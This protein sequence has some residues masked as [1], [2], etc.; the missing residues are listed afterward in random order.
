MLI[1]RDDQEFLLF[2]EQ[3]NENTNYYIHVDNPKL[4]HF[5]SRCN[6]LWELVPPSTITMALEML[7]KFYNEELVYLSKISKDPEHIKKKLIEKYDKKRAEVVLHT[8]KTS[9]NFDTEL[10]YQNLKSDLIEIYFTS[11]KHGYKIK[12]VDDNPYHWIVSFFDFEPTSHIHKDVEHLKEISALDSI[13]LELKFSA[14]TFPVI[15][16]KYD[17]IAPKL[18][19]HTLKKIFNSGAFDKEVYNPLT[20][21]GFLDSI[22][23]AIDLYGQIDFGVGYNTVEDYVDHNGENYKEMQLA[24]PLLGQLIELGKR[25][26][27][28]GM[29][30]V[31]FTDTEKDGIFC[32]HGSSEAGIRGICQQG[33]DPKRRAGQACG[34]GEYFGGTPQVSE[35]YSTS[36]HATHMIL[37]YVLKSNIT[38]QYDWGLVVD[39]PV[40][41][42]YSMCLPLLIVTIGNGKP[43]DFVKEVLN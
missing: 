42:S 30:T 23:L 15:P 11:E 16:P 19:S 7:V 18:H 14:A 43:V 24:K 35:G 25:R 41:W 40:D 12:A 32:W 33:F 28:E 27:T 39:N 8:A 6:S 1:T 31:D 9:F 26:F 38:K 29:K 4:E 2:Y 5:V 3:G 36:H 20:K 17:F 21:L 22:K 37:C 34:R 13:D 10:A